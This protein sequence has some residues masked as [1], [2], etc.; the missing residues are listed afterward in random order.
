[1]RIEFHGD[2]ELIRDF[3][4]ITEAY[5][6]LAKNALKKVGKQYKDLLRE[7]VRNKVKSD[8]KLT[9][10]F[11]VTRPIHEGGH[12]I[13]VEFSGEGRV[14]PHWHLVEH[15][16]DIIRPNVNR[17]GKPNRDAGAFLGRVAG[18][19]QIKALDDSGELNPVMEKHMLTA[20]DLAL[21]KGHAK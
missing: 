15:G 17:F 12:D 21:A 5:P 14:N 4:A 6:D 10:G 1:M 19:E 18:K 20:L 11:R 8:R 16:H 7:R 13:R 9:K 3:T 2:E